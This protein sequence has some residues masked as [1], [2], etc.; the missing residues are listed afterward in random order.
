MYQGTEFRAHKM[1]VWRNWWMHIYKHKLLREKDSLS[2][3]HGR[4]KILAILRF[5]PTMNILT[6]IVYVNEWMFVLTSVTTKRE[7]ERER[8][9]NIKDRFWNPELLIY[10]LRKKGDIIIYFIWV[11][12]LNWGLD[13][14]GCTLRLCEFSN[15]IILS[16]E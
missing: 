7:R 10:F 6:M 12:K 15:T 1:N 13:L 8:E 2:I 14:E 16:W 11:N 5:L 3:R 4:I 9:N